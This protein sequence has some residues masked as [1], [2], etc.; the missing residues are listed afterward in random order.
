MKFGVILAT[1]ITGRLKWST[2]PSYT[3]TVRMGT[4]SSPISHRKDKT[5]SGLW[6]GKRCLNYSYEFDV[7]YPIP[8]PLYPTPVLYIATSSLHHYCSSSSQDHEAHQLII[9]FSKL[10]CQMDPSKSGHSLDW[11]LIPCVCFRWAKLLTFRVVLSSPSSNFQITGAEKQFKKWR[12]ED[13]P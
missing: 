7:I 13:L 2:R 3:G 12:E 8:N 4:L 11:F 9:T 6:F 10:N 1:E 5:G